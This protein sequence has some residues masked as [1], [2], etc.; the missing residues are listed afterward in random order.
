[1]ALPTSMLYRTTQMC[2][3]RCA[4]VCLESHALQTLPFK[5]PELV[6]CA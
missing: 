3:T 6:M 5:R 4:G 2:L 1:M